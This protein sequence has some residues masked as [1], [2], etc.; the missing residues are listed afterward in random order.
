MDLYWKTLNDNGVTKER[1]LSYDRPVRSEPKFRE[2]QKDALIRDLTNYLRTLKVFFQAFSFLLLL[3][4]R[5][6]RAECFFC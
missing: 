6:S 3:H 5:F 2:D 4:R 1:M